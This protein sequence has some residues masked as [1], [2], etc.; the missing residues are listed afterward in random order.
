MKPLRD[1][2]PPYH[3]CV[4]DCDSTLSSIEGIDELAEGA[5]EEIAELTRQAMAGELALESV[6]GRRLERIRPG[7][8]RVEALGA[9]YVERMLPGAREL[10]CALRAL[11]KRVCIVSGG[12]A[13]AVETLA[14]ALGIE[15]GEVF[16]VRIEFAADGSYAGFDP[17]SPLARAGGKREVLA[18]IASAPRAAPIALVGDG[19]SDLEA[20][21]EPALARFVAF[22]GVVRRAA[23]FERARVHASA[24]DLA[25]VLPLLVS[26]SEM[27][28]LAA[29]RE[30]AG[31]CERALALQDETR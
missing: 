13:P 11:E 6:Y 14:R 5:R 7:R 28:I 12:L 29:S 30:H 16:A 20:L 22:G 8:A 10:V 17:S 27:R 4:F 3:T 15:R 9:L 25:C 1:A 24:P 26:P 21:E 31:L 19:M 23:V 2:P 18:H